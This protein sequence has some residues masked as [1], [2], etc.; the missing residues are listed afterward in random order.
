VCSDTEP[1]WCSACTSACRARAGVSAHRRPCAPCRLPCCLVSGA[2]CGRH[3]FSHAGRTEAGAGPPRGLSG[4]APP[5]PVQAGAPARAVAHADQ[6]ALLEH[7]AHVELVLGCPPPLRAAPHRSGARRAA[8]PPMPRLRSPRAACDTAAGAR[9]RSVREALSERGGAT[10][11][12]TGP[13]PRL[14]WARPASARRGGRA[15][16]RHRA[17]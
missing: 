6:V 16:A 15:P 13:R 11:S 4:H 7:A 5:A 8:A 17:G 10:W 12:R 14:E 1:S 2:G 9:S 3:L